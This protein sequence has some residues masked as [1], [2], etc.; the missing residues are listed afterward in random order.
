MNEEGIVAKI[1]VKNN[2][3]QAILEAVNLLGG[4]YCKD[5]IARTG[6]AIL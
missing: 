2:L 3:K 1:K 4:R 5:V 6:L